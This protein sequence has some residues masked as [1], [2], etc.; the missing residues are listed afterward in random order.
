MKIL[1]IHQNMPGQY[2]HLAPTLARDPANEVVFITKADRPPP[3]GVRRVLYKTSREPNPG[4][5]HYL[6]HLEGH[7]LYGQAVVRACLEL[8]RTGFRPDVICAHSG[9][10]EAMFVKDVFPDAPLLTFN[11]FYYRSRGADVGFE[12]GTAPDL[13]KMC[14][15]RMRNAHMLVSMEAADWGITPTRWQWL[16]HPEP[17]RERMTVLHDGVDTRV[18]RPDPDAALT[19]PDGRILTRRDEVITYV[20]RNLEPYR[21]FHVYM[22]TVAELCR[23]RPDAHFVLIGGDEV[24]YGVGPKDAANWR[25]K[26]LAEVTIDPRR[27]HFMGRV[28]YDQFLRT[29]QVS[30]VHVYLTYPFVLS[31]SMLESMATGCLVVGS[32]TPP[33]A[34]VIE[35]GRNGLLV[36]FFDPKAQADRIVS[37]LEHPDHMAAVRAEAR[38]TVVEKYDLFDVCLPGQIRLIQDVAARRMKPGRG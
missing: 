28:P 23:R 12:P 10:G 24:S 21:G 13:D 5:H 38:R 14:R 26:L 20:A 6:H 31:W 27:V 33:V 18:C 1:F 19:L 22:R 2:K 11:E 3:P 32:N 30:R 37:V 7:V 29:L 25:E 4:I 8:A 17:F 9:W 15:T 34:E 35:D 16:Q 36:D